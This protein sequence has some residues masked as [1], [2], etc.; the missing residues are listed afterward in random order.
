[1]IKIACVASLDPNISIHTPAFLQAVEMS[2]KF[3][4][5]S[6]VQ[7]N[8]YDDLASAQGAAIVSQKIIEDN[9]D[10]VVGHFASSAAQVAAHQYASVGLQLI[11]PA[12]TRSD[13]TQHAGVFRVCDND[14][15]YVLWLCNALDQKINAVY[16]DQ[17]AHGD[18]VIKIIQQSAAF[19]KQDEPQ[20]VLISG[21]YK[22]I[23]SF[24]GQCNAKKLIL[25]DDAFA[26]SLSADL[27]KAGL[28]FSKVRVIVGAL[29][30]QPTGKVS[31]LI[32]A[33]TKTEQVTYF[34]ETIA[35]IQIAAAKVAGNTGPYNTV[36][37]L[38]S[39]DIH[40]EAR[41]RR[42]R[43]YELNPIG[44]HIAN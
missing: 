2:Q 44:T 33:V 29:D 11:L 36:L 15:D 43:L 37:G 19:D 32:R 21:L 3:A 14:T 35:A 40:G 18:S 20:T 31:D 23:V 13:L 7:I 26:P 10:I 41:P 5:P 30:P 9:P 28:D 6:N 24:A 8:L 4:L 27:I 22:N 39:F 34:W 1:M 38:I 12:A 17:S 42:F 25:T 16:S